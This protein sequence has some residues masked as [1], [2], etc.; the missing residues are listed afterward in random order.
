MGASYSELYEEDLPVLDI[1]SLRD[2]LH[3]GRK[4]VVVIEEKI[5]PDLEGVLLVANEHNVALQIEE[6]ILLKCS[7]PSVDIAISID[8]SILKGKV[9]SKNSTFADKLSFSGSSFEEAMDLEGATFKGD[10]SFDECVFKREAKLTGAILEGLCFFGSCE[11]A[12]ELDLQMT[13]FARKAYFHESVFKKGVRHDGAVFREGIEFNKLIFGKNVDSSLRLR[14]YGEL[15]RSTD[16]E[17]EH[18]IKETGE[19]ISLSQLDKTLQRRVSRRQILR[20]VFRFL[21]EKEIKE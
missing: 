4:Q 15:G 19:H 9:H 14:N 1:E 5:I 20:S 7:L 3:T 21:P 8:Y 2:T 11:F 13:S 18:R 16:G 12:D 6:C 10:L 17:T